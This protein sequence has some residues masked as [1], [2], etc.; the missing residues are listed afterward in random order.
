M[1][2]AKNV[3]QIPKAGLVLSSAKLA[4]KTL[5]N[6]AGTCTKHFQKL[7]KYRK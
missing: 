2:E 7:N 1:Y 3:M 5:V 4:A 6:C